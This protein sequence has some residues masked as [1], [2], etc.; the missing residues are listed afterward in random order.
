MGAR[1]DGD[2]KVCLGQGRGVVDA[3]ADHGDA[4]ARLLE[5]PHL[6]DLLRREDIGHDAVSRIPGRWTTPSA[7]EGRLQ[8]CGIRARHDDLL[9]RQPR[10]VFPQA[11]SIAS[12]SGGPPANPAGAITSLPR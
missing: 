1:A 6:A 9:R 5:A 2:A 3:V 10:S 8:Q 7:P 12:S 11:R 4:V